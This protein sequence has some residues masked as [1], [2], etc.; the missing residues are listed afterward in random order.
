[1]SIIWLS[2]PVIQLAEHTQHKKGVKHMKRLSKAFAGVV[3]LILLLSVAA[4]P[5]AAYTDRQLNTA[6]AL[7]HVGLFLG[8][9][10]TYALDENL[11]RDQ[12]IVLL[13]RMLGKEQAALHG[14]WKHPFK[15]VADWVSPY[16][17]Y[18]YEH[19]ITNGTGAAT[20]SGSAVMTDQMFLTLGLRAI[21]YS[22]TA[23]KSD[24]SYGDVWSFAKKVGL[25]D[26][27]RADNSFTRGET[28]EVFWRLLHLPLKGSSVTLAENLIRQGV[29]A[30]TDWEKAIVIQANGR[31]AADGTGETGSVAPQRD[32][33][34]EVTPGP[35][36]PEEQADDSE[37]EQESL[38]TLPDVK[39]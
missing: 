27:T 3:V 12:G 28:V 16:V 5:A 25:I 37:T 14:N 6:D 9:G 35:S 33:P 8:T 34:P 7:Y 26:S 21:G 31:D 22:D 13:I 32:D 38:F 19:N 20:F 39:M 23:E 2:K 11:T 29:F 4:V 15:D 30:R 10:N 1:M 18:A 24:F 17:G 36:K